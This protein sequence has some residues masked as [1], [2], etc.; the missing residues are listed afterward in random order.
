MALDRSKFKATSVAATVQKDAELSSS[1]GRNNDRVDYLKWNNGSNLAR[2]YPPHPI[3]DEGGDVFAEPKVVV[4]LPM[5]VAQKDANHQETLDPKTRRPIMK[6]G[7]KSVFNSRIHGGTPKDLVEE[8]IA[9]S[10]EHLTED[11]K[12][13]QDAKA[14]TFIESKL[15]AITGN[16]M[17]KVQGLSYKQ[18]WVM[19]IDQIVGGV[20]KFGMVEVGRAIKERMNSI[21]ASTDTGNDPLATDPFTDIETGRAIIV[22]YDK[23]AKQANDYY[24]VE[25]DNAIENTT[26]NGKVYPLPRMFPLSDD[27]LEKFMKATPLA[28]KFRNVFKRRDFD[29]QLEGLEFFD[30]KNQIGTFEDQTWLSICEEISAYYPEEDDETVNEVEE[31]SHE[32]VDAVVV[33]ETVVE[34]PEEDKFG[35]MTRKELA[36]FAKINKTGLIIKPTLSD[37]SIRESLREWELAQ[38]T[39]VDEVQTDDNEDAAP[40]IHEEIP[41]VVET[42]SKT[43]A[44]ATTVSTQDR[45][46]EMRKRMQK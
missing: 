27:Q 41:P 19:Y 7:S 1:L 11:L 31:A 37:D 35:L 38:E 25:L 18:G 23:D 21:A 45:L 32:V 33:A 9:F 15:E 6:E 8:Y 22:N 29:L 13:C 46:A 20:P 28:K 3:E 24:K 34:E 44:A 4:W 2:I 10:R 14:K 5:M 43:P 12:V 40:E 30:S 16:F 17:K 36:D 26:I 42:P 39:Y